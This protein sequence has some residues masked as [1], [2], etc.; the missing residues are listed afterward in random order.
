MASS[1]FTASEMHQ[2]GSFLDVFASPATLVPAP[3][4]AL[5][6]AT[7]SLTGGGPLE[8]ADL[9]WATGLSEDDLHAALRDGQA[10]GM[11][12]AQ[13][14]LIVR[15][16]LAGSSRPL[17]KAM[18]ELDA[19]AWPPPPPKRPL[20]ALP[21]QPLQRKRPRLSPE[22]EPVKK[23]APAPAG[24]GGAKPRAALLSPSQKKANHI[25][26]EQKR[27]ANIRRGYDA[28]CAAVPALIEECAKSKGAP[29]SEGL[30]LGKTIEHV[31][32]LLAKQ[33]ALLQRLHDARSTRPAVPPLADAPK[34]ERKWDGGTGAM[35]DLDQDDGEGADESDED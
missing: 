23:A 21:L 9:S 20:D 13:E 3:D 34:W 12:R 18:N 28:L 11:R 26:S 35:D 1:L 32:E 24:G 31:Q 27:R 2:L 15:T 4:A 16:A 29:R 33:A 5:S 14:D 25:Q 30:V 7:R 19:F 10:A 8:P 6:R 22:P 17:A